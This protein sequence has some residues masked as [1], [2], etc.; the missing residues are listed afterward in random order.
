MTS[1]SIT[2][3]VLAALLAIPA[4]AQAQ[5]RRSTT[6]GNGIWLGGGIGFEAG[7]SNGYQLR[8]EGDFPITR[9]TPELQLSGVGTVSYAGLSHDLSVLEFTPAARFTWTATPQLGAYGDLGLGL[10]HAWANGASD[11][12]ATMRFGAGGYYQINTTTRFFGEIALHPHFGDYNDTTF[13][14]LF[15]ARFR[16]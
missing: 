14:M 5:T 16:I 8:F 1:R 9:L 6:T 10:F 11:T 7:D 15:G 13:T 2:G 3:L 4:A 12:G